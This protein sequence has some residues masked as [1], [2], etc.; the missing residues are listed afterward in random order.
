MKQFK[1]SAKNLAQLNIDNTCLRCFWNL[2]QLRHKTPF[3]I[4]PSFYFLHVRQP[5][6]TAR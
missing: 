3:N 4:F 6:E 5:S 2:L 1:I